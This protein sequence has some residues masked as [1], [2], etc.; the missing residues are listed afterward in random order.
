M[1]FCVLLRSSHAAVG[2]AVSGCTARS[3]ILLDLTQHNSQETDW[4]E[5][6]KEGGELLT[7]SRFSLPSL[8]AVFVSF[9]LSFVFVSPLYFLPSSSLRPSVC[10]TR[11][12]FFS[13][14]ACRAVGVDSGQ[15]DVSLCSL[16]RLQFLLFSPFLSSF[17]RAPIKCCRGKIELSLS[18]CDWELKHCPALYVL[19]NPSY[20]PPELTPRS[21]CTRCDD[22][23]AVSVSV[24]SLCFVRRL[25]YFLSFGLLF[26]SQLAHPAAIPS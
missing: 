16:E 14:C 12:I 21:M 17:Y 25:T 8:R 20:F 1:T 10:L 23:C 6:R 24:F 26:S 15:R 13:F 3:D 9:C 5:G 7:A 19:Q 18:R 2:S 11:P 4:A 22:V